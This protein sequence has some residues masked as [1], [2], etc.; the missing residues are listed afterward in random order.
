MNPKLLYSNTKGEKLCKIAEIDQYNNA[1]PKVL[2]I[3]KE[4][5]TRG[6]NRNYNFKQSLKDWAKPIRMWRLLAY[7]SEGFQTIGQ[8]ETPCFERKSPE[9]CKKMLEHSSYMNLKRF[10]EETSSNMSLV[11]LHAG[12]FWPL[13]MDEIKELK[14][15]I[16]VFCGTFTI[17][18]ELIK[19]L[20]KLPDYSQKFCYESLGK[21]EEIDNNIGLWK[22]NNIIQRAIGLI[23]MMH[24]ATR[25]K[26]MTHKVYFEDLMKLGQKLW[27]NKKIRD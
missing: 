26:G 24:P 25:K 18:E 15:H 20:N 17:F 4:P 16:I 1:K 19:C 8:N 2:F 22:C 23:K 5:S 21:I 27:E 9:K 7:C 13:M 12:L 3:L 14:P 6:D 11:G 10:G